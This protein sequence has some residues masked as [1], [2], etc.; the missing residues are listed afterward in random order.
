MKPIGI[1]EERIA[2]LEAEQKTL[3]ERLSFVE[4][5]LITLYHERDEV[6]E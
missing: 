5:R 4:K 2:N 6:L 3:N 1:I